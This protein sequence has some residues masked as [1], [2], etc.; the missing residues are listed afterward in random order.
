MAAIGKEVDRDIDRITGGGLVHDEKGAILYQPWGFGEN[1]E[2]YIAKG[3][4][5]ITAV[6]ESAKPVPSAPRGAHSC[7]TRA[8]RVAVCT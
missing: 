6:S 2:V 3:V 5:V 4:V 7:V 1:G 8:S